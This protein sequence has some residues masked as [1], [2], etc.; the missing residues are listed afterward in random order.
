MENK[1]KEDLIDKL[2]VFM[3]DD[4][5]EKGV[6][7]NQV[8]FD[9]QENG[10]DLLNYSNLNKITNEITIAIYNSCISR[11]YLKRKLAYRD[12][13]IL[14]TEEGQGKAISSKNKNNEFLSKIS[15][16]I[17]IGTI[18]SSGQFQVGHSNSQQYEIKLKN[19]I[20]EIDCSNNSQEE[21]KQAKQ[22]LK[23]FINQP[24]VTAILGAA[25]GS[26]LSLL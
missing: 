7:L 11:G 19:L 4:I 20:E 12:Y 22:A 23:N 18:N 25:T 9:F 26:L 3:N 14:I 17:N 15:G 5:E 1:E 16:D 21:K 6:L 2:L 10:E 24:I 8:S 13:E